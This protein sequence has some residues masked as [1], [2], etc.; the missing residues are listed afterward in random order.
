MINKLKI[1]INSGRLHF[2]V[3]T[4]KYF[5]QGLFNL[6]LKNFF[7]N[8][9]LLKG[10]EDTIEFLKQNKTEYE[11]HDM[12]G[13]YY[14][15]SNEEY[16]YA[17][18]WNVCT[19]IKTS[20]FILFL[21][22]IQ[23]FLTE[24]DSVEKVKSLIYKTMS[25]STPTLSKGDIVRYNI[26]LD[27]QTNFILIL[28][29]EEV[30]LTLDEYLSNFKFPNY[31]K[32]GKEKIVFS[33]QKIDCFYSIAELKQQFIIS[34]ENQNKTDYNLT[35]RQSPLSHNDVSPTKESL[36]INGYFLSEPIIYEDYHAGNKQID[37][38]YFAYN[39][40]ENGETRKVVK[41]NSS[42]F[43]EN[44]FLSCKNIGTYNE[45]E[46]I[47]E[48]KFTNPKY[49]Q[50]VETFTKVKKNELLNADMVTFNYVSILNE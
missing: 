27:N 16:T 28:N 2:E 19:R 15:R 23:N 44:D 9:N 5:S 24:W 3:D 1:I 48:I 11:Y 47:I 45:Y 38:M 32:E 37:E 30:K 17:E 42:S 7:N 26:E 36:R 10:C 13:E 25:E 29:P 22:N 43:S 46:F 39:F 41:F 40:N 50:K 8:D 14:L 34:Q 21:Q 12:Q 35:K 6:N 33:K 49:I 31:L 20:D 18:I 4:R